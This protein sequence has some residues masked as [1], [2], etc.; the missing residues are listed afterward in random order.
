MPVEAR[1]P[2][3]TA[4]WLRSAFSAKSTS[5]VSW[6]SRGWPV[7]GKGSQV[8]TTAARVGR[9]ARSCACEF[10]ALCVKRT[11]PDPQKRPGTL[12]ERQP[13]LPCQIHRPRGCWPRQNRPPASARQA[14]AQWPA[15]PCRL[16]WASKTSG[17]DRG[18]SHP[19]PRPRQ[20]GRIGALAIQ[21]HQ[22][23]GIPKDL[24]LPSL[25]LAPPGEHGP[26]LV[27]I[28]AARRAKIRR[29]S[30]QAP[31]DHDREGSQQTW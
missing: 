10:P 25:A 31:S 14:C 22:V 11:K 17:W 28:P 18:R 20:C 29:R 1:Q 23:V 13:G 16:K 7:I 24:L 9:S 6:S 5:V 15:C 12:G 3:A 27:P 26:V 4:G 19:R 30:R 21:G 2:R 8:G